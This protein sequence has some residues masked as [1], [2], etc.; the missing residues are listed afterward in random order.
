MILAL[1][2]DLALAEQAGERAPD[3][4]Q[5]LLRWADWDATVTPLVE[6]GNGDSK[7]GGCLG[8]PPEPFW[9]VHLILQRCDAV[10]WRVGFAMPRT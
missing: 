2:I 9:L 3:G 6:R 5:P 8:D 1:M 10:M 4:K 7:E